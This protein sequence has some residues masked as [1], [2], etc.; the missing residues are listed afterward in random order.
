MIWAGITL[1]L[2]TGLHCVGMCGPI[3]L[4]LPGKGQSRGQRWVNRFNYHLGRSLVYGMLGGLAGVIGH[5]IELFTWQRSVALAGGV[6]MLLF[7]FLPKLTR[8][9]SMPQPLREPIDQARSKL[10]RS[11]HSGNT[12][13]WAGLGALN[14]LLP[15]GPLYIA[16]AGAL[17]VGNW[18]GGAL[19]MLLFGAGTATA[20][21]AL[22]F[23]RDRVQPFTQ[24]FSKVLTWT[25][26]LVG[27]LLVLRGLDLGIPFLSP[28]Q[29]IAIGTAGC[30]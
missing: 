15:C 10:F 13:T 2:L 16:L 26:A 11:L 19:F 8:A 29:T 30:H 22:H 27:V 25:T 6:L 18:A 12:F 20:L 7:V 23:M 5:G 24:R 21:M 28:S 1:G 14:G 9:W 3:V 4:A 17:A